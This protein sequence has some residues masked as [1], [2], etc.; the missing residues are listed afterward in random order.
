MASPL[1]DQEQKVSEVSET[2]SNKGFYSLTKELP[3]EEEPPV[4]IG[5]R[6]CGPKKIFE[7]PLSPS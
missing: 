4:L 2:K 6:Q 1:E 3:D 5:G 7:S